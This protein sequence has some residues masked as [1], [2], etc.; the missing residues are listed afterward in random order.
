MFV[1]A[2]CQVCSGSSVQWLCGDTSTLRN[3][4]MLTFGDVSHIFTNSQNSLRFKKFLVTRSLGMFLPPRE[5][6]GSWTS[7]QVGRFSHWKWQG[8]DNMYN[9][10]QVASKCCRKL[11]GLEDFVS[12]YISYVWS[13]FFFFRNVNWSLGQPFAFLFIST[14]ALI[15][16]FT[17]LFVL[18]RRLIGKGFRQKRPLRGF[19]LLNKLQENILFYKTQLFFSFFSHWHNLFC[20]FYFQFLISPDDAF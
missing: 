7:G 15:T 12:F 16:I 13:W 6:R 14:A 2:F 3:F 17:T 19:Q 9:L 5:S 4:P 18:L 11:I 1:F 8:E 10:G 20:L